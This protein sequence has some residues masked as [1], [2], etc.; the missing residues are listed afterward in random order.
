MSNPVFSN[1]P[2]FSAKAASAKPPRTRRRRRRSPIPTAAQL[3]AALRAPGCHGRPDGPH[4]LRGHHRQDRWSASSCSS[5]VRRSAGS[6]PIAAHPGAIVGFVLGAGQ[7]LQARAVARARSWPTASPRAC[8]SA[9]SRPGTT[10]QFDSGIVPMAVFGTLGVVAVTLALFASGKVR[11]SKRA[12]KIFLVAIVGY[13]AFS[14]V[15]LGLMAVRRHR[16]RCT[17]CATSTI[18]GTSIPLGDPAR[19]P[20][21]AAGRVL[22]GDR[23]RL[24]SSAST[25]APPL[26]LDRRLRHHGHRGLA[27]PRDP[28]PAVDFI[29]CG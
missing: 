4:D 13:L 28:A 19:H 15:N 6:S 2:A 18:P 5:S 25:G 9:P 3:D 23:L 21:R 12:T 10:Q 17:G 20:R 1:S 27:L 29:R 16:T 26:R 24:V 14:L 8:S 7:H 11:A 22:A